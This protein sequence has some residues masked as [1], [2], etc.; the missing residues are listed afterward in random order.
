MARCSQVVLTTGSKLSDVASGEELKTL[1][2]HSSFVNSV[3]F[4]PDGKILAGGSGNT[5][6]LWDVASGQEMEDS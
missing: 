4:S 1:K 2:G 5:I 6:K 3:A